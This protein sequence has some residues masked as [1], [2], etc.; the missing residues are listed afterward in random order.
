MA[1]SYHA[2]KSRTG[3]KRYNVYR[4]T[5]ILFLFFFVGI[6][7]S[8]AGD[9]FSFNGVSF[10]DF[11]EQNM[12]CVAGDCDPSDSLVTFKKR[13][14]NLI[15]SYQREK[16]LTQYG[17][18]PLV[19]I[20]YDYF[21]EKLFSIRLLLA[22]DTKESPVCLESVVEQLM[23][24]YSMGLVRKENNK[25]DIRVRTYVIDNS[26]I[27]QA[28]S[29]NI[30]MPHYYPVLAIRDKVLTDAVRKKANPA[31]TPIPIGGK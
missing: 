8:I 28:K 31:Y 1:E 5:F 23:L 22:C 18:V 4:Y 19:Q 10:G 3:Q 9:I 6:T 17:R 26:I 29:D 7:Q 12:I 24:T 13:K 25:D 20:Y 14:V 15:K 21:D 11:P 2:R 16:D 30:T 27:V